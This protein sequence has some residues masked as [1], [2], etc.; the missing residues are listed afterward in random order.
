MSVGDDFKVPPLSWAAIELKADRFRQQ[1]GLDAY[2]RAP[3]SELIEQVLDYQL[4]LVRFE[5]GSRKEMGQAEGY[6]CPN[7]E[8]IMLREDVY[9]GVCAGEGRA[10]FT[11]AH[12]LGHWYMHT[13]IP[14]ARAKQGDGT[15]PFCLAE[16]QANQFAAQFLMP[17]RFIFPTD[18]EEDLMKRFGVTWEPARNRLRYLQKSGGSNERRLRLA[19]EPPNGFLH[20]ASGA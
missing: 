18:R 10:R 7:G 9:E 3:V 20:R 4:G 16:P 17:R 13:N 12:E 15:R 2:P 11:A 5:V 14:L 1:F 8:F 19:P 6:T